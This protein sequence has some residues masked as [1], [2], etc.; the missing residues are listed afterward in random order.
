MDSSLRDCC[1]ADDLEGMK[2]LIRQGMG[3]PLDIIGGLPILLVSEPF[4]SSC[5]LR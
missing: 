1:A 4:D 5:T 3:S 2:R